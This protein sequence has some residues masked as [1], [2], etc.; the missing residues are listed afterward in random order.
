VTVG[1]AF[2]A[3][4]VVLVDGVEE[5][6][7]PD[8]D[9]EDG[10]G[11]EGEDEEIHGVISLRGG[12]EL[13]GFIYE[14]HPS[15]CGLWRGVGVELDEVDD[16]A[17]ADDGERGAFGAEALE[18]PTAD[19]L[20]GGDAVVDA[21]GGE[22]IQDAAGVAESDGE[23]AEYVLVGVLAVGVDFELIDDAGDAVD[24]LCGV[25]GFDDLDAGLDGAAKVDDA[26]GDLDAD[27]TGVDVGLPGDLAHEVAE[28]AL[29]GG[30]RELEECGHGWSPF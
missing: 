11:E 5:G 20:E 1:L 9:G 6:E 28:D 13:A 2:A 10:D 30:I 25:L 23:V 4:G 16:V 19:A 27:A 12:Y 29:V 15:G 24:G 21:G 22:L 18:L 3:V 8:D 7:V 17:D 26:V 14:V